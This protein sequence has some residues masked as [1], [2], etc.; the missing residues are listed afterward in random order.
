MA[1]FRSQFADRIL[2]VAYADLVA[3]PRETLSGVLDFIGAAWHESVM[4]TGD[5]VR[6]VRTASA[7]QARQ[8]LY[9]HALGRWQHYYEIAPRFF[10]AIKEIDAED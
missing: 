3:A 2:E 7:W 4:E 1:R 6:A 5:Q 9:R 8:P 10:D